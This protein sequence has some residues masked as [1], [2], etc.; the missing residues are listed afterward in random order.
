MLSPSTVFEWANTAALAAWLLLIIIPNLSVTRWLV[1]SGIVSLVLAVFY[2]IYLFSNFDPAGFEAFNS[3]EGIMSLNNK[4]ELALA[5]WIH[6]LVF[7]LFVGIWEVGNARKLGI[8]H[9]L[10]IPALIFTF[11]LGPVGLMLYF[12]TRSL[13][14]KRWISEPV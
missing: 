9:W 5:G 14:L 6:Y 1:R 10:I 4:P 13:Y 7:D 3:L 11:M 2:A 12:L 8:P